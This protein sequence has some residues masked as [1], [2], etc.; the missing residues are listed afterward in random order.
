M[1][2]TVWSLTQYG[3]AH[4][5]KQECAIRCYIMLDY[6]DRKLIDFLADVDICKQ[7]LQILD[8]F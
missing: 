1:E 8:M 3:F 5:N 4:E 7:V 2:S 6:Y